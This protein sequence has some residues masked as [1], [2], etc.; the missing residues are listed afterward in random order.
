M[1]TYQPKESEVRRDKHVLDAEGQVLGRFATKIADLLTGKAKPSFS[2]HMDMGDFVTV[3]NAKLVKLT[4]KKES[5]KVYRSHSGYPGGYDEVAVAKVRREQPERIIKHAV[6][7][8]LPKNRLQA[9]RMAR[10]RFA[11]AGKQD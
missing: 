4:G 3:K 10:L 7:G 11:S 1:K 2:R 8:M 9:D 6:K 5:Q